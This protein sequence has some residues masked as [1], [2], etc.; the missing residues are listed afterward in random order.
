MIEN[1]PRILIYALN[2][3][4]LGHVNRTV[5]IARELRIILRDHLHCPHSILF[6]TEANDTFLI[7]DARFPCYNLPLHVGATAIY[8]TLK[9]KTVSPLL[10]KPIVDKI[11][12][13]FKPDISIF[14]FYFEN[15]LLEAAK[16]V[17]S[18]LVLILRKQP[19][20]I[21]SKRFEIPGT[22]QLFD[23]IIIPEDTTP[24]DKQQVPKQIK[25]KVVYTPPIVRRFSKI[26]KKHHKDRQSE[27]LRRYSINKKETTVTA[28]AG[29]GGFPDTENY[30]KNV[31]TAFESLSKKL[32]DFHGIIFKGPSYEGN[33]QTSCKNIDIWGYE[34]HL[35]NVL[36]DSTIAITQAGYNT[37]NEIIVSS[38]PAIVVPGHRKSDDQFERAKSLADEN[39]I[40]LLTETEGDYSAVLEIEILELLQNN[41]YKLKE[42]QTNIQA[43]KFKPGN[44]KT[45]KAILSTMDKKKLQFKSKII[46]LPI[47]DWPANSSHGA[48]VGLWKDITGQLKSD[49]VLPLMRLN[50][51]LFPNFED[52]KK[53]D[54]DSCQ[55]L[56]TLREILLFLVSFNCCYLCLEFL[57]NPK[58]V[59]LLLWLSAQNLPI[60]IIP[61]EENEPINSILSVY[62]GAQ[63]DF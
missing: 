53:E 13:H 37:I 31:L 15:D 33:L 30:Y 16:S 22:I 38:I 36:S 23:K 17:G 62:E 45:A 42:L 41:K 6:V 54:L 9:G 11:I 5:L 21:L 43:K 40:R 12:R 29:A 27:I 4:G 63:N 2:G 25:S 39:C 28:S 60:K 7:K 20:H 61:K 35:I 52:S 50:L 1:C 34:P 44:R 46:H 49:Y 57:R 51:E 10:N 58:I 32:S 26:D 56:I 55:I 47:E 14:D 48:P 18:K 24:F 19:D 3:V 8:H 59:G